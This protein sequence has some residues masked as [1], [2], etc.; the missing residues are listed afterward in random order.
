MKENRASEGGSPMLALG[1]KT[2]PA[3]G[4]KALRPAGAQEPLPKQTPPHQPTGRG[5]MLQRFGGARTDI[6]MLLILA[7]G[8]LWTIASRVPSAIGAPLSSS[9]SPR[10]GFLAPA[11][12]LDTL[13]GGTVALPDLRGKVV[14]VNFWASWC[15][16]CRQETPALQAVYQQYKDSGVVVVGLNLTN[17]DSMADV[18]TF[19]HAY[20][21]TYPILL[22][23]DGSVGLQY[24]VQGLPSTFFVSRKGVIRTVV[25]GGP[26]SDTFVRSKVE[27][28]LAEGE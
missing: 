14:V 26:M 4:R 3:A 8:I 19:A 16:P 22:D 6:V 27:A 12:T 18:R 28:L 1:K 15:F 17:Q 11:F 23:R 5:Q 13:A 20:G 7:A 25:V 9:P 10:E 21:L 24:R 2:R